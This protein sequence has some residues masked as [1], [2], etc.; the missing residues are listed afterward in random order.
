MNKTREFALAALVAC[1]SSTWVEANDTLLAA[2]VQSP[3]SGLVVVRTGDVDG[4]GRPDLAESDGTVVRWI[5]S[6]TGSV[7]RS[8]VLGG[9]AGQ[10]V[11]LVDV[12][13]LDADGVADL[14]VGLEAV[15]TYSGATGQVLWQIPAPSP[16]FGHALVRVDD[17]DGDG[18]S[19]ILVGV[20]EMAVWGGGDVVH[21]T[22]VG[23]G[24]AEIRSGATGAL[25]ATLAPPPGSSRGFGGSLAIV[26]DL[27]GDGRADLAIAPFFQPPTIPGPFGASGDVRLYSGATLAQIGSIPSPPNRSTRVTTLGD[28]DGDGF[29]E[30]ALARV[31]ESVVVVAPATGTVLRSHVSLTTYDR[32]GQSIADLGDVDGDGVSDYAIGAPQP[33]QTGPFGFSFD[34]GP[35]AVRVHSGVTG[36]TL[37]T[38]AGTEPYGRF[39]WSLANTGD[40]DGDLIADLAV[41]S[42]QAGRLA[43]YSGSTHNSAPNPYCVGGLTT[44]TQRARLLHAG[45][46]S[47]SANDLSLAVSD[48]LPGQSG[49]FVY[50]RSAAFSTFGGGWR[51]IG[52]PLF[53]LGPV[54]VI[55]AGGSATRVLDLTAPP[56]AG[57]PG[58]IGAGTTVYFQFLFRDLLPNHGG[59]NASSALAVTFVP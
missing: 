14:A 39:G 18:L 13:D 29:G 41:G 30:L 59:R 17:R 37:F 24:R 36:A 10:H 27:D 58:A 44:G 52:S 46:T 9:F 34:A 35:G 42:P 28:L 11:A 4:D 55:D 33:L 48:A 40:L 32:Y 47:I 22:Y 38:L 20:P 49:L 7:V 19:E 23:D 15:W 8:A 2:T 54:I 1:A 12:G 16:G 51:C 31:W 56:A 45:T 6:A 21:T 53:R 43:V 3:G 25:L 57:G 5:S 26:D 50:A